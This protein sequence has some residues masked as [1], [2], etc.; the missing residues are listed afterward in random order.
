M[1]TDGSAGKVVLPVTAG[2]LTGGVSACEAPVC[3][4]C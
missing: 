4:F 2:N 3:E 1:V